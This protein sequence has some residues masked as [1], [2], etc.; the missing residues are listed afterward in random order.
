M[1]GARTVFGWLSAR[2]EDGA[3]RHA[4][5]QQHYARACE[6][7]AHFL[8]EDAMA[9]ADAVVPMV[10]TQHGRH[11]DAAAV[12]KQR[13]RVDTRKWFASKLYPKVY[14]DR[15]A[16]EVTGAD[17]GPVEVVALVATVDYGAVLER[18]R[19]KR[20]LR[21]AADKPTGSR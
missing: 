18:V 12:N 1:P 4:D 16:T 21:N 11:M 9:V 3:A 2:G 19:M 6:E 20:E 15:V 8:A 13:L 14:G 7:R 17:G 5:F 10:D